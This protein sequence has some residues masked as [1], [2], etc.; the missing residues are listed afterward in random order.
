VLMERLLEI[1][2]PSERTAAETPEAHAKPE[3]KPGRANGNARTT[4]NSVK[5]K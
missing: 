3:R 5:Q 1:L 2:R 4:R